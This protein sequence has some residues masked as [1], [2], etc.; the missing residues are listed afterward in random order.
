MNLKKKLKDNILTIGSWITIA[1]PIIA[2][3]IS[4]SNFD[5]VAIDLE[6][7]SINIS[8][9]ENLIRVIELSNNIPLVRVTSNN[10]DLIK[11]VMDSG[12]HGIIVPMINNADDAKKAVSYTKYPSEGSRSF[13]LA[14]AQFYGNYFK[15][16]VSS[17]KN[18]LV[19]I[20]QVESIESVNNLEAILKVKGVDGVMIG[21][22][23]LSGSMGIPG[24]FNNKR[25]KNIIDKINSKCKKLKK[26][27]GIHVVE[28]DEKEL[29]KRVE[30]GYKF[31]AYSLD[32]VI[33]SREVLRA[34]KFIK[35]IK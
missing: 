19:V 26:V 32:S 14:R 28:P 18:S 34:E 9:A 5:W 30:E 23:D 33:L 17:S 2:E 15:K 35:K 31:I 1:S 6:H 12:A 22:Y 7:S 3:I 21:P 11:R 24:D 29:K 16:Y 10:S 25:F 27:C 8:E 4:K 13:G 20:V